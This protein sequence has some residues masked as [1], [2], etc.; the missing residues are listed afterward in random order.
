MSGGD[1]GGVKPAS[2]VV[3]EVAASLTVSVV[4]EVVVA[5]SDEG[6]EVEI[7]KLPVLICTGLEGVWPV[8]A[9][10]EVSWSPV[11]QTGVPAEFSTHSCLVVN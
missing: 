4:V 6:V 8:L 2:L 11:M 9:S 5:T 10:I 1:V 7:V 3:V